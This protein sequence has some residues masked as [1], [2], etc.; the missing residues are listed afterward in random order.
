M[1][2][3]TNWSSAEDKALCRVW[4]TA[5][6]LQ[7]Q[8]GDHKASNFWNMVRELF[9]QELE[10]A[11]ERPLNGLKVRWTRINRDSQKFAAIFSEIQSKGMKQEQVSGG[12]SG[13]AAAVALL[14]E[15][16]WIDEAK[17]AFHRYY[18]TKFSFESCWKQLRY[19]T[20]WLQL[21]ADS[22]SNPVV[23]VSSLPTSTVE[24]TPAEG[25]TTTTDLVPTTTKSASPPRS[26]NPSAPS[27]TAA[28]AVAA[29]IQGS[30]EPSNFSIRSSH[31]RRA[32]E[33]LDSFSHSSSL[34]LQGLTATLVEELKR[35]NDL[36][37]DQNA[38]ALLKING[39]SLPEEAEDCY[40]VL[41]A[42][43]MK[44]A[45]TNDSYSNNGRTSTLV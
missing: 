33:A 6:D 27:V 37:E 12:D 31:K 23:I 45:R 35:Q 9:H 42:R 3:K 32:D 14:T 10:T 44:K 17:D 15:Q 7:L 16:Q 36:L 40:E 2:K 5:S 41:R 43:Y 22:R 34:Q 20:K 30:T 39:E 13:D 38:I 29:V 11:V 4:L 26:N 19:S 24:F 25:A 1:G 21:F 18:N 8:G 28:A